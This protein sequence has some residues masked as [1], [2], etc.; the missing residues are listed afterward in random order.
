MHMILQEVNREPSC[1]KD[2]T[3]GLESQQPAKYRKLRLALGKHS[4]IRFCATDVVS[5][6]NKLQ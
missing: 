6:Q 3:T 5:I 4:N 2:T 1:R